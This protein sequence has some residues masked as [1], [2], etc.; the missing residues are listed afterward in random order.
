MMGQPDICFKVWISFEI[1][2]GKLKIDVFPSMD[3]DNAYF[4]KRIGGYYLEGKELYNDEA[5]WSHTGWRS[6]VFELDKNENSQ[7]VIFW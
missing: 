5:Y 7:L 2:C 1:A 6:D 4:L 3:P